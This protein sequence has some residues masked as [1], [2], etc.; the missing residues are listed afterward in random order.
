MGIQTSF[1]ISY[2]ILLTTA[3]ICFIEAIRT[4]SPMIRHI[5]NLETCISVVAGY[6]Y[7]LFIEKLKGYEKK[8]NWK[9]LTQLRYLDWAITTP[10]MLIVLCAALAYNIKVQV[11]ASVIIPIIVLN[12]IMLYFGYIGESFSHSKRKD[13]VFSSIISFAAFF[14][15]YAIIFYYYVRPK[16]N[17]PNYVFYTLYLVAWTL[18]G[19]VYYFEEETKNICLNALDVFSK[20]LIGIGLWFYYTKIIT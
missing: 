9:E 18:Y 14:M 17:L 1:M 15:M 5:F 19:V 4:T 13:K 20:S 3:T 12:Y 16:Y 11:H 7:Y 10:L 2:I 6:F 8:I